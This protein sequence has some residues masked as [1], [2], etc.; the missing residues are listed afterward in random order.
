MQNVKFLKKKKIDK[1]L[2]NRIR[3]GAKVFHHEF[4]LDS[5]IC[6]VVARNVL[7]FQQVRVLAM[8]FFGMKGLIY[9]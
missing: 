3:A 2:Y 5:S 1:N 8:L 9:Y 6:C 7:V 4:A